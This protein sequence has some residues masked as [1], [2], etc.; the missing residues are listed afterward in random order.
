MEVN[1][2]TAGTVSGAGTHEFASMVAINTTA[3]SSDFVFINWTKGTDVVSTTAAFDYTMPAENVTLV[4]NYQDVT[5][6]ANNNI[7]GVNVYPNPS[8]GIF[9]IVAGQEYNMQVVDVTGRLVV[10]KQIQNGLTVL[11]ME[12]FK[13]GVYFIR[14]MSESQIKTIRIIKQ[15]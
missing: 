6:I 3:T 8:N 2:S 12:P 1:P 10:A 4:A 15:Q 5:S 7:E 13:S 14:L 9:N 11:D